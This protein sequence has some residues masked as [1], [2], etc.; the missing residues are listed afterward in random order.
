MCVSF[1]STLVWF[2]AMNFW[3]VTV[4]ASLRMT[5]LPVSFSLCSCLSPDVYEW[6]SM[7]LEETLPVPAGLHRAPLPVSTPADAASSGSARQQAACLPHIFEARR[8]ETR[9]ASKHIAYSADAN[10]LSVYLTFDTS[11]AP[12]VWRYLS[13]NAETFASLC[14]FEWREEKMLVMHLVSP[15]LCFSAD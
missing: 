4:S 12:L 13:V 14:D 6:R 5:T 10:A 2:I 15:F 8:P 7:Q 1:S 3:P 11:R 9:G